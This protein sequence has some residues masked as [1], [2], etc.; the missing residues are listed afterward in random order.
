LQRQ[1]ANANEKLKIQ[2]KNH[3]FVLIKQ[4]EQQLKRSLLVHGEG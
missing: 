2:Q 3:L 4:S 1:N